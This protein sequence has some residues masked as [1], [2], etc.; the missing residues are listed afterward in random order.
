MTVA[1]HAPLSRLVDIGG[2]LRGQPPLRAVRDHG[3]AIS[4]ALDPTNVGRRSMPHAGL[5]NHTAAIPAR[6]EGQAAN[7]RPSR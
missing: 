6:A 4:H 2:S 1:T 7:F 5:T 3:P